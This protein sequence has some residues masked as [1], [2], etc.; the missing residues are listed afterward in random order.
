MKMIE[1]KKA[2]K[3][4]QFLPFVSFALNQYSRLYVNYEGLTISDITNM[5]HLNSIILL[6]TIILFK[7]YPLTLSNTQTTTKKSLFF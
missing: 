5:I 6:S 7:N 4:I 1:K 2:S 3:S